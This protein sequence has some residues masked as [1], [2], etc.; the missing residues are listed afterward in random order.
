MTFFLRTALVYGGYSAAD[1]AYALSCY[2]IS[3]EIL[4]FWIQGIKEIL[5]I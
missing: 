2:K 3:L 5:I 4:A 1:I